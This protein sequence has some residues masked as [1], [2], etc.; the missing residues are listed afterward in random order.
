MAA[1]YVLEL[2]AENRVL[3]LA[4]LLGVGMLIA[5][6]RVRGVS[7]GAA[8]VLVLSI[9]IT[10]YASTRGV[11]LQLSH[12]IST[13]GLVLFA[14]AIVAMLA[15]FA[16]AAVA[17]AVLGR[18]LGLDSATIAGAFAGATTNT[19]ALPAAGEASGDPSSATVGYAIAYI[20]GVLGMLGVAVFS[21][22]RGKHDT[23]APEPVLNRTVRVDRT[24]QPTVHDISVY[25]G[26]EVLFSR[27]SRGDNNP[28]TIPHADTRLEHGDLIT[29]A[30]SQAQIDKAIEY[31]GESAN[32]SLNLDRRELDFRR[33]TVSNSSL[34][35]KK[36]AEVDRE[37]IERFDA[38][39]MR[40]RRGA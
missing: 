22:S 23:D 4:L 20:G 36:V 2:L 16:V 9:V 15:I 17:A 8:A 30:G 35:G 38:Y 19:P 21:L 7:L 12:E 27:L 31:L 11:E 6:V 18:A 3:F 1:Q 14:F 25:V 10:A 13:F 37:L 26:T 32:E 39:V 29:V 34:A 33:I 40:I 5:R 28:L 24:D